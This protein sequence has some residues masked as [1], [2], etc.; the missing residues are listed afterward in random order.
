MKYLQTLCEQ[1]GV[2]LTLKH[3]CPYLN[4]LEESLLR[5]AVQKQSTQYALHLLKALSLKILFLL[6]HSA[7]LWGESPWQ[8]L[9]NRSQSALAA[10][11]ESQQLRMA[12]HQADEVISTAGVTESVRTKIWSGVKGHAV[13]SDHQAQRYESV[14]QECLT[15]QTALNELEDAVSTTLS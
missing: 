5:E 12:L 15:R 3:Y 13:L 6:Q 2:H 4:A 11:G 10:R 1:G 8:S 9:L 14:R 7:F